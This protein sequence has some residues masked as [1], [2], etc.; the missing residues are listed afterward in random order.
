[1]GL[2]RGNREKEKE[3]KNENGDL[4]FIIGGSCDF[5]KQQRIGEDTAF[6]LILSPFCFC[7]FLVCAFLIFS[8]SIFNTD[9][10]Q[11]TLW[12]LY[13]MHFCFLSL[14]LILRGFPLLISLLPF[15]CAPS[16][17]SLPSPLPHSNPFSTS[18]ICLLTYKPFTSFS[19]W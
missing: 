3:K 6:S 15:T 14:F 7:F 17:S 12:V 18:P 1:M 9:H 4:N 13:I 11:I 2:K 16:H 10:F 8:F 5:W 19:L